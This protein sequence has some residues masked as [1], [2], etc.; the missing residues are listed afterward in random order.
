MHN[1]YIH[2]IR[3]TFPTQTSPTQKIL[4][5]FRN[6]KV[7]NRPLITP[8]EFMCHTQ[9]F[10]TY[11]IIKQE[12]KGEISLLYAASLTHGPHP[13]K[14][15]TRNLVHFWSTKMNC[16]FLCSMLISAC[17]VRKADIKGVFVIFI[18]NF[19]FVQVLS[20][21]WVRHFSF[22]NCVKFSW[23]FELIFVTILFVDI[24]SFVP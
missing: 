8:F 9:N 17:F 4:S 21:L 3:Q 10:P 5:H 11:L 2:K 16:P 23:W 6:Y 24:F 7:N 13:K 20:V 12:R 15:V 22:F 18:V 1:I 14:K 19:D